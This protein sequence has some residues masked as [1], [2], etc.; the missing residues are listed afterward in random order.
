MYVD[1]ISQLLAQAGHSVTV[2]TA[3]SIDSVETPETNRT[4][5]RFMRQ[6]G[7]ETLKLGYS[8]TLYKDYLDHTLQLIEQNGSLSGRIRII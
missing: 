6:T 5:V 1:T 7:I 3:D 8:I 4:I 2:L